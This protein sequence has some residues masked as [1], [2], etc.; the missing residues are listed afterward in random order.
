MIGTLLIFIGSLLIP[1][2]ADAQLFVGLTGDFGNRVHTTPDPPGDLFRKP[3]TPSP[4]FI[5]L[6]ETRVHN[7]WY[8]Q[9][10]AGTGILGYNIKILPYD[11]LPGYHNN[12]HESFPSYTTFYFNGVIG[13]GKR[14]P[15]KN[16][17]FLELNFGGGLTYYT[18][19]KEEGG[20]GKSRSVSLFEYEMS[21]KNG[22]PKG[23]LE[24][25]IQTNLTNRIRMGLHYRYHINPALTGSYNFDQARSSGQLSLTH[26]TLGILFLVRISSVRKE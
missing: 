9:Y 26:R 10:G 22:S 2:I 12:T 16:G 1:C 8:L 5:V 11:T 23:F 4:G 14:F 7:N 19:Y 24:G 17:R 20:L 13:V 25:S 15:L 6:V 21:R 3:I 18:N